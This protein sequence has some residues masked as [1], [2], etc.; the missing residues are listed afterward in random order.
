MATDDG[1]VIAYATTDGQ[2]FRSTV[3]EKTDFLTGTTKLAANT[4]K[5]PAVENKTDGPDYLFVLG[6]GQQVLTLWNDGTIV[7]FDTRLQGN[8]ALAE[9]INVQGMTAELVESTLAGFLAAAQMMRTRLG[10]SDAR[11]GASED[12]DASASNDTESMFI[13]M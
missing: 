8:E 9:T 1:F 4:T 11:S 6:L 13:K 5:L 2:L 12:S 7:R 3:E 10:A